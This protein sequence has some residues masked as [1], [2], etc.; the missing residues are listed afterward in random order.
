M[1]IAYGFSLIEL[2]ITLLLVTVISF[3]LLQQQWQINQLFYRAVQRSFAM[4]LLDN[5]S[6]RLLAHQPLI[7]TQEPFTFKQTP[8][9]KGITLEI[10]WGFEMS[11]SSSSCCKL[12]R[13][14]MRNYG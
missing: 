11:D 7:D 10:F 13:E 14:T 12:Q 9:S 8:T 6:E 3:A 2:L 1:K 4:I 5:N